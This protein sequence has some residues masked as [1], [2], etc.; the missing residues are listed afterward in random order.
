[1]RIGTDYQAVI[2]DLEEGLFLFLYACVHAILTYTLY[3]NHHL[4]FYLLEIGLTPI[5]ECH[6]STWQ[7]KIFI[8]N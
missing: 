1:M 8:D 3:T 2:P 6:A 7:S 5:T 4:T